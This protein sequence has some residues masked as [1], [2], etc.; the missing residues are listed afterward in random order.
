MYFATA[1]GAR[2]SILAMADKSWT[3]N[4]LVD[5]LGEYEAQVKASGKAPSTIKTYIDHPE[6]FLRWLVGRYQP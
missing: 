6:R 3:Y 2:C 4:E 1:P 5:L